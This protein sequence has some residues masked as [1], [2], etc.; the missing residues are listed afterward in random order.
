M[1]RLYLLD[2]VISLLIL[3]VGGQIVLGVGGQIVLGVRG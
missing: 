2:Q 1:G 3:G